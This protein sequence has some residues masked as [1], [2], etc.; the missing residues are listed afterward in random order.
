MAENIETPELPK[1]IKTPSLPTK[2]QLGMK[3]ALGLSEPFMQEKARLLPKITEAKGA[4]EEAK[5]AQQVTGLAGEEQAVKQFATEEKGAQDAYQAKIEKEP[6]PAFIPS[7]ENA[8]DI[9]GLFS[10]VSVMGALL[11]GTGKLNS[12]QALSAMNGM[13]E[14]HQKGRADLYK[15]QATE[16]DKAFKGM[17]AKHSEFRKEMEDAIR[18]SAT[19]KEAG[20]AAARLAA[21]KAGSPIVKAMLD[22]DRQLDAYKLVN[23][24]QTLAENAFNAEAKLRSEAEKEA[25]AERR[26]KQTLESQERL[27]KATL[28]AAQGRRDEKALQAIGPALRNIAEN[29]PEGS[30]DKLI[31]ASTEDKKIVQGSYRAIEESE[32]VADF[33][34][35]NPKA[36]GA[37]AAI[38]NFIKMD[39]I[40]SIKN[41]DEATAAQQKSQ[42][43]DTAIDQAVQ[44]GTV[45]KDDAEAAKILQKKLFGLA[46]SDVRGSG[47]RG[48]VYLD[49][50]FQNLYDQ[51][52]RQDTLLNIVK[53][54]AE[55]NN[56]N[57]RVYK[58]NVER[59]NNPE[60]FPLI[61]AK[62]TADYIKERAPQKQPTAQ[63]LDLLKKN[64]SEEMKN[65]FDEIYGSGA[66]NR[67][68]GAK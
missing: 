43:I 55:D 52:S 60:Q 58:L 56:R 1:V 10:M 24:S 17:L 36:V 20:M 32:Q 30:A 6:L 25:S 50:S 53:E 61:E 63:H 11:G 67:V 66:A 19:N 12:M 47:Q 65:H 9:A 22:Q 38:K 8:N 7:K 14:G 64:P 40:K 5:Q 37:M 62:S 3:E 35:R 49:K 29:Y 39:A 42:A 59:H 51:A 48:S 2:G 41:E 23:E 34:A 16:F 26:H 33:I 57:L 31:G 68:L 45:T 54:R 44:S 28:T 18:L 21:A 15:K 27:R 13:L 4:V 46:L